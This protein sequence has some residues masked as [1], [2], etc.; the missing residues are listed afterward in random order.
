MSGP[1]N[2]S[3]F[4]ALI[5]RFR[6]DKK[7]N[8]AVI[9]GIALV[10]ILTAIGCATDYSLAVRMKAKMQSAADG[11]SVS[12]I[13]TNSAGYLAATTMT[14]DGAVSAGVIDANNIFN[15][16]VAGIP[17]YTNL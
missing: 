13:S 4:A 15:G 12:S 2:S 14:S 8:V 1:R 17:G 7:A 9:F 11:A 5:F 6:R 3:G 16:N 10:P